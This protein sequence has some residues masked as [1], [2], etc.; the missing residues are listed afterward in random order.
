[1]QALAVAVCTRHRRLL[2][3]AVADIA[4]AQALSEIDDTVHLAA[5]RFFADQLRQNEIVLTG[6]LVLRIPQRDR[7]YRATS[8]RC[9]AAAGARDH[10]SDAGPVTHRDTERRATTPRYHGGSGGRTG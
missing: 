5:P 10:R 2:C 8:G 4:T 7:A 3:A 9:T 1:M 6:A